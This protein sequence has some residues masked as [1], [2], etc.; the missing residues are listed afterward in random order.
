MVSEGEIGRMAVAAASLRDIEAVK[1]VLQADVV[2][3]EA[4]QAVNASGKYNKKCEAV[5][6]NLKK[7]I[8]VNALLF[9]D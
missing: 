2:V 5:A 7:V 8:N 3:Y 4:I 1:R 9:A 6:T